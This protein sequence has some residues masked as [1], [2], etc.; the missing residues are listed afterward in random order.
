MAIDI[1]TVQKFKGTLSAKADVVTR[2]SENYGACHKRWSA[3]AEK[4]AVSVSEFL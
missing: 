1:A 2:E 3:A 4:P